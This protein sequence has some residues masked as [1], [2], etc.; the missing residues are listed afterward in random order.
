MNS[1]RWLLLIFFLGSLLA[2]AQEQDFS[3]VFTEEQRL[4]GFA[5]HNQVNRDSD[6]VRE[7]GVNVVKKERVE[8][9]EHLRS[10][11]QEY[12]D[13]KA[14]QAQSLDEKSPEYKEEKQ[15]QRRKIKEHEEFQAEYVK[16][17]N[18]QLA[19]RNSN[20]RLTEEHEYHLD[21]LVVRADI[22]N[23][24]LYG[25]KVSWMKAAKSSA[26]SSGSSS[27]SRGGS[28]QSSPDFAP[29]PPASGPDFYEPEVPPP[30]P[31][32]GTFDDAIP[33]PIFDD[34]EF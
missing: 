12:R 34:P 11:I 20:V 7:S 1:F 17:R 13:W 16:E 31:E 10:A 6:Q 30:P 5:Q 29:P 26:G 2:E 25:G 28:T 14:R 8:W 21:D 27:G 4:M 19:K 33:P 15:N 22:K 24:A 23:R 3:Q 32:P 9:S 18:R